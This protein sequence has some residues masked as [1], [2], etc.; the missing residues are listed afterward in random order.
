M[1]NIQS[2]VSI[3]VLFFLIL[4]IGLLIP[5]YMVWESRERVL[6]EKLYLSKG[7]ILNKKE[8]MKWWEQLYRTHEDGCA[9]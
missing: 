5:T 7:N 9:D 8:K 3:K 1:L 6:V 2:F 4:L